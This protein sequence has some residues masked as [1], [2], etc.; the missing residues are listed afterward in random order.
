VAV[1][2]EEC[3]IQICR[4]K[5]TTPFFRLLAPLVVAMAPMMAIMLAQAVQ[6]VEHLIVEEHLAQEI[7]AVIRL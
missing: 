3:C 6:V 7:K 5:A 1:E 4:V 2:Q